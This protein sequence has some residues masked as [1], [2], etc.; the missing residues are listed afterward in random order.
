MA[1]IVADHREKNGAIPFLEVCIVEN[2]NTNS[3][4]PIGKGG[5]DIKYAEKQ[6]T[7]GDYTIMLDPMNGA[8]D[9]AQMAMIVERK[10]WKD[11]AASIKDS[12]M[13][14]QQQGMVKIAQSSG[15]YVYY[16]IEGKFAYKD[17]SDV[18]G[19]P[20]KSLHT[21]IRHNLLRGFP[22]VQTN[23]AMGTAKLLVNF[24]RD[25]M[26]F[27]AEKE[28]C[29]RPRD[30]C[31]GYH[32][33]LEQ[34]QNKYRGLLKEKESELFKVIEDS[35][36]IVESVHSE[37]KNDVPKVDRIV[38]I[39]LTT[40]R[41]KSDSDIICNMW[42]SLNGVSD[43][44]AVILMKE[45]K[46]STLIT[47]EPQHKAKIKLKI[48]NFVYPGGTRTFGTA[49]ADKILVIGYDGEDESQIEKCRL[50]SIKMLACVPGI[51][52]ASAENIINNYSLRA[53]CSSGIT[54]DDIG[55]VQVGKAKLGSAKA[56]KIMDLLQ[57]FG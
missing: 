48:S 27:R 43:K 6:L 44:S 45:Y 28:L 4:L 16:I 5:G 46:L 9:E 10:T 56:E 41:I 40:R 13:R 12:R 18:C 22:F 39:E 11:L 37:S 3:K 15:C 2:N 34:L 32:Q 29:I 54:T 21:K 31:I 30:I 49:M 20:F 53:M 1:T 57:S 24:T 42:I 50:A 7:I 52:K 17:H 51:T 33:E 38:P 36:Q 26:R 55:A 35:L 8:D 23:D 25:L 14:E 47:A 19:L